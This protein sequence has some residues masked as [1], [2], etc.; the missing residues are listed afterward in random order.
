MPMMNKLLLIS[1]LIFCSAS[2]VAKI[3]F[4]EQATVTTVSDGMLVNGKKVKAWTFSGQ[5][6]STEIAAYYTQLWQGRSDKFDD[7]T[8]SGWRI[9]NAVIDDI[10]YSAKIPELN[11][12]D[13]LTYVSSMEEPDSDLIKLDKALENFPKPLGTYVVTDVKAK[14]GVKLSN[15]LLMRNSLSIAENLNF[16]DSYFKKYGWDID[17]SAYTQDQQSGVFMA[18]KGPENINITFDRERQYSIITAVRVDVQL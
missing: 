3:E 8:L 4:P 16:Y 9:I 5:L 13:N 6:S 1:A 17:T 10:H 15:T 2:A 18:R 11:A 14:D 7:Q 12:E